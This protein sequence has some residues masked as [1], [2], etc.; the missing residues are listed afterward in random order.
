MNAVRRVV[1]GIRRVLAAWAEAG[2]DP[3]DAAIGSASLNISERIVGA[4]KRLWQWR[5][6]AAAAQPS[7][8]SGEPR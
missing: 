7:N 1:R 5:R 2:F 4:A 3:G 6:P 8:E